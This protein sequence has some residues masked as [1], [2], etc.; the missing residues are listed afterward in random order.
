[1]G[2]TPS[3]MFFAQAIRMAASTARM[4][5]VAG[6]GAPYSRILKTVVT[7]GRERS[8]HATKGWRNRRA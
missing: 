3:P 8:L 2:K 1:M 6:R 4:R 7:G 5:P